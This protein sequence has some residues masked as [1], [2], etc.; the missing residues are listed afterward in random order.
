MLGYSL[1]MNRAITLVE[2][3][4]KDCHLLRHYIIMNCL[5]PRQGLCATGAHYIAEHPNKLRP[6]STLGSFLHTPLVRQMH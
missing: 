3:M 2:L 4:E 5:T 1:L 6:W